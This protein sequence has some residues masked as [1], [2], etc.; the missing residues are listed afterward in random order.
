VSGPIW[1]LKGDVLVYKAI[2]VIT[3]S[4][5]SEQRDVMALEC[6]YDLKARY[7][8]IAIKGREPQSN[9]RLG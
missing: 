4:V 6:S 9:S 7:F 3:A 5:R 2:P 1:C 8:V